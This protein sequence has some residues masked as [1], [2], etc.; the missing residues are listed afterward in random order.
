MEDRFE[1]GWIIPESR[2]TENEF[3]S[4]MRMSREEIDS[5]NTTQ[6]RK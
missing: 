5:P 4:E 3:V 1:A 2:D 6:P